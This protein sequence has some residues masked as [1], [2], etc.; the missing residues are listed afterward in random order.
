[1]FSLPLLLGVGFLDMV[2]KAFFGLKNG[3]ASGILALMLLSLLVVVASLAVVVVVGN[4]DI[5]DVA[6]VE[7]HFVVVFES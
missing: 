4:I 1:M 5:S 3:I 6:F 2:I 7:T